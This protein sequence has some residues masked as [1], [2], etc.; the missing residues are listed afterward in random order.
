M[1]VKSTFALTIII[2]A[3]SGALAATKTATLPNGGSGGF[4]TGPYHHGTPMDR[5]P[6]WRGGYYQGNDPD[7]NIRLQLMRD[8]RNYVH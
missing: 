7:Q 6:I 3:A 8:G 5:N 4:S 2:G 1:F